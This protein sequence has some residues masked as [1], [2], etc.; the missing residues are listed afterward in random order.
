MG[1]EIRAGPN[2]IWCEGVGSPVTA[3]QKFGYCAMPTARIFLPHTTHTHTQ[4]RML[5]ADSV[6]WAHSPVRGHPRGS[7]VVPLN[8]WGRG[9][10]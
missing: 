1:H 3:L 2:L 6:M 9:S 5:I 7:K 4:V 8:S 10:Y